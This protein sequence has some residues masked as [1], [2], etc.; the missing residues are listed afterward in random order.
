[1]SY[2]LIVIPQV[3]VL[4]REAKC[5]GSAVNIWP[6]I[7]QGCGCFNFPARFGP[8]A[9]GIFWLQLLAVLRQSCCSTADRSWAKFRPDMSSLIWT[10]FHRLG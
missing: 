7:M 8:P 3:A 9:R 4:A 10:F 6:W 1:M 2:L 5:T